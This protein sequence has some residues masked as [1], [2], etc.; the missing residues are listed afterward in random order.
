[1]RL[2]SNRKNGRSAVAVT[3][4]DDLI[5]LAALVPGAPADMKSVIAGWDGLRGQLDGHAAKVPAA[6]RSPLASAQLLPP[7]PDPGKIV[8]SG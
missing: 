3:E 6:Q 2:V 4:G 5:D 1:M 7:V 8:C